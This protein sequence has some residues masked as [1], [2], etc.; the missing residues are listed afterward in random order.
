M[1]SL[2]NSAKRATERFK[3]NTPNLGL[4]FFEKLG[5]P[6]QLATFGFHRK[7]PKSRE[8]SPIGGRGAGDC[9]VPGQ[10]Q[11]AD[12]F[13][14]FL[15][16]LWFSWCF[17]PFW[18]SFKTTP[19]KKVPSKKEDPDCQTELSPCVGPSNKLAICLCRTL[20]FR[21]LL[22]T[23]SVLKQQPLTFGGQSRAR[24]TNLN[25]VGKSVINT[26]RREHVNAVP[27]QKK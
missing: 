24:A 25:L 4:S 15:G 16:C 10:Q 20:S 11:G 8:N 5:C 1:V 19:Q 26:D 14:G 6:F 7:T 27:P 2:S 23:Y 17:F 18:P 13:G 3:N 21:I 12:L 9:Q 22:P